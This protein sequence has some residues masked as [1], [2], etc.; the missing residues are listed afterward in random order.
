MAVT[1]TSWPFDTKLR[2]HRSSPFCLSSNFRAEL[3]PTKTNRYN[4]PKTVFRFDVN[5]PIV[6]DG[7]LSCDR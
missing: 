5:G 3:N 4:R 6:R 2:M 1:T 7:K